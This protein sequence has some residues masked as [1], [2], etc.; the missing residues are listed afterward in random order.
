MNSL[1]GKGKLGKTIQVRLVSDFQAAKRYYQEVFGCQVDGWGH[2]E[3]DEMIFILQ[4]ANSPAD[5]QPNTRSKKR[6][7][8]PTEW[9]GPDFGWDSFIHVEW[10]DFDLLVNEFQNNGAIVAVEPFT[11][12]H[13]EYEFK[14]VIFHDLDKYSIVLGAMRKSI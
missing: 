8:Y 12:S 7:D 4:Q 11:G 5:V 3:R 10:T 13:G 1:T 14:N 9:E 6:N 2:V